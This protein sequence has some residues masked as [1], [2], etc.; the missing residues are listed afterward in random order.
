MAASGLMATGCGGDSQGPSEPHD[1]VVFLSARTGRSWIY[2]MNPDGS[3]KTVLSS[4]S[5]ANYDL[6]VSTAAG[7]VL[8]LKNGGVDPTGIYWMKRDGTGITGP[9]PDGEYTWSPDAS[10]LAMVT[11]TDADPVTHISV[12]NADGSG[13]LPLT[14]GAEPDVS[15]A[16]SPDGETL[17]FQR[18]VS[19]SPGAEVFLISAAGGSP[20]PLTAG[21]MPA[22]SPDGS[23][24]AFLGQSDPDRGLWTIHPDGTSPQR[25]STANCTGRPPAWSP[26]AAYLLCIGPSPLTLPSYLYRVKADGSE[27]VNLTPA[28]LGTSV[29]GD[30]LN[31]ISWSPDNSRIVFDQMV[32][33]T[34]DA[35]AMNADGTNVL[36]LTNDPQGAFEPFWVAGQ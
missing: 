19:A 11:S 18:N 1:R 25:I 36:N 4:D 20:S 12:M 29:A 2:T 22:W 8:F 27:T 16:W 14:S 32:G 3:D 7:R 9:L 24:I 31:V 17:V 10:R 34:S 28:G 13:L 15:P 21:A 35:Y 33:N 5:T 26:D 30:G 23:R 6:E